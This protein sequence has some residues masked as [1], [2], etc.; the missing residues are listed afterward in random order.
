MGGERTFVESFAPINISAAVHVRKDA[1]SMPKL[2]RRE[3]NQW[4]LRLPECLQATE[5]N[6]SLCPSKL[7]GCS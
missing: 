4:N 6:H 2:A 5:G 3:R 7:I 1:I